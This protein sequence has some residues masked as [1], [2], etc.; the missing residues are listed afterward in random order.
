MRRTL[1]G[2]AA[3]GLL[4]VTGCSDSENEDGGAA[5]SDGGSAGEFCDGFEALNDRF[6]EDPAAA[7]DPVQVLDELESL[8]PP[9]E[10]AD[11]YQKVIDVSRQS[12]EVDIEDPEAVEEVQQLGEEAADA[13]EDVAAFLQDECGIDLG[14]PSE[15]DSGTAEEE[16]PAE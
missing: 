6:A 3:A 11:A 13:E 5:A 12:S 1:I 10:I 15:G 14:A 2:L 4:A 16:Q 8:D 9:D 7:S